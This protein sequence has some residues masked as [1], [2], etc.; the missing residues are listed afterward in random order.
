MGSS[1]P[2]NHELCRDRVLTVHVG[3]LTCDRIVLE[4]EL[5][6]RTKG[7]SAACCAAE[8]PFATSCRAIFSNEAASLDRPRHRGPR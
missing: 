7:S 1:L 8:G 4:S 5:N 6:D 2:C 3:R